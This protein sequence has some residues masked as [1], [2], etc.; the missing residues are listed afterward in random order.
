MAALPA[1]IDTKQIE[2]K[3]QP[4]L[5][6]FATRIASLEDRAKRLGVTRTI[7]E[8]AQE[9]D[10]D[11]KRWLDN[12]DA[13]TKPHKK[14][15]FDAHRWFTGFCEKMAAGPTHARAVAR[16]LIGTFQVEQQRIADE[17][18]RAAEE[19]A[20]AEAERQRQAEIDARLAEAAEAEKA[21]KPEMAEFILQEAHDA[22]SAPLTPVAV[23]EV[24]PTK[25]EGTSVS[26]RL[27]GTVRNSAAYVC[28]LLGVEL[29]PAIAARANLLT[30]VI[31]SWSQSGINAQL[32]R[33]LTFSED[34]LGVERM[35]IVRNLS[36]R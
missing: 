19:V 20:R 3:H 13:E 17:K 30:E 8:E 9:I 29:T 24:A 18:R 15:L 5:T 10:T 35:P 23:A 4:S 12:W 7:A 2:T 34:A 11:A 16:R 36:G 33:G 6:G 21:G 31:A 14:Q 26:F 1:P 22:E 28:E 32:K 25:V 27:V